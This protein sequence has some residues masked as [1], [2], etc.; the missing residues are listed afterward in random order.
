MFLCFSYITAHTD[1]EG[2]SEEEKGWVI[3]SGA[4]VVRSEEET[5]LANL[6]QNVDHLHGGSVDDKK[7]SFRLLLEEKEQVLSDKCPNISFIV[8]S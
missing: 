1:T 2:E 3:S 5:K 6:L 7:K 4:T 8:L